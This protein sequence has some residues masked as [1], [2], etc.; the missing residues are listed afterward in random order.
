MMSIETV[1]VGIDFSDE[2]DAALQH[3]VRICSHT[4]ASLVLAHAYRTA[5]LAYVASM[6]PQNVAERLVRELKSRSRARLHELCD[7]YAGHGVSMS[8]VLLNRQPDHSLTTQARAIGAD[9]IVVGTRGRTGLERVVLGSVAER[10]VRHSD[11]AV[12][13]ARRCG[14]GDG[15]YLRVLVPT[16]F[17]DHAE[18]ALNTALSLIGKDGAIDLLHCWRLPSALPSAWAPDMDAGSYVPLREK[19]IATVD[20]WGAELVGRYRSKCQKISFHHVEEAAVP[21]ILHRFETTAY[22]LVVMGSR[23]RRGLR[24]WLLG[25]VAEATVRHAPCSVIVVHETGEVSAEIVASVDS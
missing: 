14:L 5:N 22:D 12:M 8:C 11:A 17:S 23:G 2:S 4:G 16:D 18:R 19:L 6:S 9:L 21:G 20:E 15:G 10:T 13:V 7:Q 1:L 3:A 24:R 25:S